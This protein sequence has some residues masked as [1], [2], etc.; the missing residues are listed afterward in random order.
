MFSNCS[1][2]S[3]FLFLTGIVRRRWR[4]FCGVLEPPANAASQRVLFSP[5]EKTIPK[6]RIQT[7]QLDV[8]LGQQVVVAIDAWPRNSKYP[9]VCMGWDTGAIIVSECLAQW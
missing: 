1:S 7:R 8:L 2:R 6:V 9:M 5:Q 4:Q 3:R